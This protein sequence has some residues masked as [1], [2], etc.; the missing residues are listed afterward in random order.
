MSAPI[1]TVLDAMKIDSGKPESAINAEPLS[2]SVDPNLRKVAADPLPF[3]EC[4][5]CFDSEDGSS[6][7]EEDSVDDKEWETF[8][9]IL[10]PIP[11]SDDRE[12]A[13]MR[14]ARALLQQVRPRF[15]AFPRR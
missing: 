12:Q 4:P 14:R 2:H 8:L 11:E 13:C 9:L 10:A 15:P 6:D 5:A 7:S 3:S 1:H